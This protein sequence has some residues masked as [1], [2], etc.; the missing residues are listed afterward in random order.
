MLLKALILAG[1]VA[2]AGPAL[3]SSSK[4]TVSGGEIRASLGASPNSAAYM[5]IAND[6]AQPDQLLSVTCACAASAVPH[7]SEMKGGVMTMK[8]TGPLAIRGHG[9]LLFQPGGLH[10]MLTGLKRP[11]VAGQRQ[12]MVLRFA[13]AGS[14]RAHFE[15]KDRLDTPSAPTEGDMGSMP[16]M[17]AMPGMHH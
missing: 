9:R 8:A 7:R 15:V 5:T 3:A 11:L 16:G 17:G 10:V 12:D 1:L 13:H 2:A 6:G 14:I 4:I